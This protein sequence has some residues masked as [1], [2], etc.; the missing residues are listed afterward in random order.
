MLMVA[1]PI[2]GEEEK[3]ALAEVI[4]SGWITM[5]DRVRS[6]ECAF[7]EQHNASDC[8]AVN[9]CTA[10]LHLI[11]EGLGVGRGDEVLVPS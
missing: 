10:A 7:A 4:D 9:S 3:A 1:E 11:L 5:G 6:F 8:V 2:L